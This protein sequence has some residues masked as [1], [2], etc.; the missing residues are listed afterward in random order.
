MNAGTVTRPSDAARAQAAAQVLAAYAAGLRYENLPAVAIERAKQLLIDTLGCAIFGARFPWSQAVLVEAVESGATG[1]CA[2]PGS[3]TVRLEASK[4]A[5]V[6]GAYSHA[7]ELDSLRKPGSGVHG[8][9]TVAA[10]ALAMA[11]SLNTSGRDL[12]T[13]IV[14]GCEVMF[15]IGA[16]TLHSSEKLGFHAPG[17]TGP[18]GS[19]ISAALL[20]GM[21]ADQIVNAMGIAG[22]LA[23]GLLA[24]AKAG[25]GGMVKR[26]HLGRAAES[27]IV[28]ARLAG[29]GFEGPAT[30]LEGRYGVL[31]AFCDENDPSLLTA[32]LGREWEIEKLCFKRYACHTTA[33]PPVQILREW[34]AEHGF[35]G[36]DIEDLTIEA[37]PKVVSH[38]S[39]VSP[40]DIMLAQYSVPFTTAIAAYHDPEEPRIFTD[41]L[42]ADG[43]VTAL[44]QRI[45]VS[46]RSSGK[47]WHVRMTLRLK[48]GRILQ[49]ESGSFLGCPDTPFSAD[50]LR[51]KFD[52]LVRDDSAAVREHLFEKLMHLQEVAAVRDLPFV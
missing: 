23:G 32:G 52:R 7:F 44:A 29:R 19:A 11:M 49:G 20:K 47:G 45:R 38:H 10:P 24:F 2:I 46:E 15:R 48:D 34:I 43:R 39:D 27:G 9:A 8:G 28:A 35:S 16:A 18:F 36:D 33:H 41:E 12:I 17:I 30:V 1:P 5:L 51:A 4:A 42:T 13:A 22:S 21:G 25:S 37:S 31:E 6:L 14:A 3:A 26:L 50:Q 40:T